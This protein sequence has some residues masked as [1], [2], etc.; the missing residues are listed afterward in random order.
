MRNLR[1]LFLS[2]I[3]LSMAT[4]SHALRVTSGFS[5][6][7]FEPD[8]AGQGFVLEIIDQG[9]GPTGVVYWFTF[10]ENGNRL[11]LIGSAGVID[12]DEVRFPVDEVVGGVLSP[13]GFDNSSLEVI[14][15]GDLT[16]RF[17]S[18]AEGTASWTPDASPIGPGQIPIV[19]LTQIR[20]TDCS[21]G[22]SDDVGS[23]EFVNQTVAL[24]NAG[25]YPA[26]SGEIRYVQA[27]GN[28]EFNVEV[29]DLPEG[30]YRLVVGGVERAAI[31]VLDRGDGS[32]Q[33]EIEFESPAD[34]NNDIL[35]DFNVIGQAVEIFEDMT[36]V[37]SSEISANPGPTDPG[38]AAQIEISLTP[39][40]AAGGGQAKAEYERDNDTKFEVEV[41]DVPAGI[42]DLL[43]DGSLR[44][45]FE[46]SSDDDSSEGGEGRITFRSPMRPDAELLDF[47]VLGSSISIQSEGVE[48][49]FGEFPEE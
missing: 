1:T 39:T 3:A 35:L 46:V 27:P 28:V 33:G 15:W 49:F 21:G 19:R 11:W 47:Q 18:C 20:S 41:E 36:L 25:V 2:L 22:I 45:S 42:Y 38:P 48:F 24:G 16:L 32:T 10:D 34:S 43:I 7:W 44:G 30:D 23:S 12:G 5:G 31:A 29:E 9:N 17:S 13:A 4:T 14:A 37:L 26:A 8:A 6:S 40:S